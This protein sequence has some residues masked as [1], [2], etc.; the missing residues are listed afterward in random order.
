[1]SYLSLL[2]SNEPESILHEGS[3]AIIESGLAG[4]LSTGEIAVYFAM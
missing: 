4:A 1:V 3:V 2:D